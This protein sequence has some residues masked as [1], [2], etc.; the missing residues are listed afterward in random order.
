MWTSSSD[1]MVLR[2]ITARRLAAITARSARTTNCG[3]CLRTNSGIACKSA[4]SPCS[5]LDI[6][7]RCNGLSDFQRE[8]ERRRPA[9]FEPA[10]VLIDQIDLQRIGA[11]LNGTSVFNDDGARLV[12]RE[13]PGQRRLSVKFIEHLVRFIENLHPQN[14]R[15]PPQVSSAPPESVARISHQEI[16]PK[17]LS[18]RESGRP[19]RA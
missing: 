8:R 7:A 10:N 9:F 16:S 6:S 1:V 15:A 11:R 4:E 13:R 14:D 3:Q 12:R 5:V 19:G 18:G 2:L 17:C